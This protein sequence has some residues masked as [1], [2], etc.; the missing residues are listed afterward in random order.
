MDFIYDLPTWFFVVFVFSLMFVANE[1][2]YRIGRTRHA[3]EDD[4]SHSV[5]TS[6]KAAILGLVALLFGFSYSITSSRYSQRQRVVL[7]EAN[8]I[9]TCYLRARLLAE[10]AR[11]RMQDALRNY[12]DMRLEHFEKGLDPAEYQ[13]TS[14]AMDVLLSELWSAVEDGVKADSELAR[15][16]QIVPAANEVIDMSATRAWASHNHLPV[17]TLLLMAVCMVVSGG[18]QG[19]SSG[20][21]RRRHLEL[22][23]TLNVLVML[24]LFVVIDFDRP[25]RGFIRVNHAPLIELQ[26]SMRR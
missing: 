26:K 12:T 17:S 21:V 15:T 13:R 20:Q 5:S 19:H 16:A 10:P 6:Q 2:G 7:D 11:S 23:L 3:N 1:V 25:R 14:A 22:W 8:A 18:L 24:L 9:G 4:R